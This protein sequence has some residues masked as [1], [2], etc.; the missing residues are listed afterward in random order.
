LSIHE[1]RQEYNRL[2]LAEEELDPDPILQ[3]HRWFEEATQSEIVEPNAMVLATASVDGQP[4]ARV[5]LLRGYDKR[6]FVF[7]TNYE[8]RKGR[9]LEHNP[10]AALVFYW[11]KLER[12]V[13]I[14]GPVA[15]VSAEESDAYFQSRPVG[16][17]LS[18]WASRQTEVIADRQTLE[19][20]MRD[21]EAQ[22]ADDRVPRPEYWGGYRVAPMGIEFWQGRPNRLHDRLR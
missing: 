12:Q 13:R 11:H 21:L 15:R 19:A 17:R 4:A 7:F 8:S 5:V 3:F 18:A 10:R 9:D 22:F 2:S 1:S 6:G 14:E 16:A 20:R